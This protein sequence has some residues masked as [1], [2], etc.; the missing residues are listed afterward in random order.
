MKACMKKKPQ[1]F[2]RV[3]HGGTANKSQNLLLKKKKKNRVKPQ[4]LALEKKRRKI[5]S[6]P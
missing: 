6:N 4:N 2:L 5:A 3:D 1:Q